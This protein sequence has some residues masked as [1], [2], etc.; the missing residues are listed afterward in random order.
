MPGSQIPTETAVAAETTT[1]WSRRRRPL[2]WRRALRGSVPYALLAPVV[3]VM[4]AV[5]GYPL[6]KLV[7]L[8]FQRYGLAELIQRQ[9]EWIGFD[10]YSSVLQDEDLLA[11]AGS[12]RSSSRSRTSA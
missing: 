8:S 6:Y 12:A 4:V 1:V 10:N 2:T 3:I 5:L 11:D 7:V 9:G